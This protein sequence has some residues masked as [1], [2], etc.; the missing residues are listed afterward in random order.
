MKPRNTKIRANNYKEGYGPSPAVKP[1]PT[2][3]TNRRTVCNQSQMIA[4]SSCADTREIVFAFPGKRVLSRLYQK[5]CI[6]KII[7]FREKLQTANIIFFNKMD[8]IML[9][10]DVFSHKPREKKKPAVDIYPGTIARSNCRENTALFRGQMKNLLHDAKK[11]ILRRYEKTLLLLASWLEKDAV[12]LNPVI[13]EVVYPDQLY[14]KNKTPNPQILSFTGLPVNQLQTN[15]IFENMLADFLHDTKCFLA[16]LRYTCNGFRKLFKIDDLRSDL[17]NMF[18][19]PALLTA[20]T[21]QTTP[22]VSAAN[23]GYP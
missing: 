12:Q 2:A 11:V 1:L 5:Y 9:S 18:L 13:F 10:E 4:L 14:R 6:G 17:K 15:E 16:E 22:Y 19:K 8:A 23:P 7:W 3:G 21:A 20:P